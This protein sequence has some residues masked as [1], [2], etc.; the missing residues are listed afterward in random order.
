MLPLPRH[1]VLGN[2]RSVVDL[3]AVE[4]SLHPSRTDLGAEGYELLIEAGGTAIV[5]ATEH[6]LWNGHCTLRQLMAVDGSAPHAHVIDTPR[7]AWRGAMLDVARHFFTVDEVKRFISL[8]SR[9]KLNRLHLHLTDDQGWRLDIPGWPA[10]ARHGGST[11]TNG[12]PGGYYTLDDWREIVHHGERHFVTV[13]PEIDMPGHTNAALASV[14][15]LNVDGVCPPLY[16]GK[17][18]GFS[19]LRMHLP[20][21]E[22]FVH[23]VV[24][25][26]A[27]NTPG[28]WLHIGGDEAHS[29]DHAEYVAFIEL[30]Q[31]EVAATGKRMVAWEE[32]GAAPLHR[33][34]VVQHW[35]STDKV[36]AAPTGVGVVLSPASHTYLDMRHDEDDPLGRRWAGDIDVDAAYGWDPVDVVPGLAADRIVG[37]EAPLWTEKVPTFDAVEHLCFPR[38][39][40][41]AEVGWTPQP[42][43]Q[44][45]DFRVRLQHETNRLAMEGVNVHR[46][47]LL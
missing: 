26:L 9:Y 27:E 18:V 36:A 2:E 34:T 4:T 38:L 41:L 22:R 5:A 47:K 6:G 11:A 39:L 23:D 31:R 12:D 43:R 17:Q 25:T 44:W 24:R 8:I 33:D 46:S 29:T 15:E 13:V 14:P 3:D 45:D 32:A 42:M 7:F 21:T 40:C 35:L 19:S 10:L 20:A 37:V 16:T 28:P 1:A 30:L